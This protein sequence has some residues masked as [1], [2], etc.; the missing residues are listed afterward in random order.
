MPC[1]HCLDCQ[2]P[3]D[4]CQ[5]NVPLVP[6]TW[7]PELPAC[8]DGC[9]QDVW[10]DCVL[11]SEAM[12]LCGDTLPV[13]TQLTDILQQVVAAL[14][15][16]NVPCS[17]VTKTISYTYTGLTKALSYYDTLDPQ[18]FTKSDVI[19]SIGINDNSSVTGDS[20]AYLKYSSLPLLSQHILTSATIGDTFNLPTNTCG[21]HLV[22][23]TNEIWTEMLTTR[24]CFE[25]KVCSLDADRIPWSERWY[26][27]YRANPQ[28]NDMPIIN[29]SGVATNVD[30]GVLYLNDVRPFS[31]I[32]SNGGIVRKVFLNASGTDS[33][34]VRTIAGNITNGSAPVTYNNVWG[35]VV[36][37]DYNSSI[38]IDKR[39]LT[40]GEPALYF[41]TLG[42]VVCR[43]VRERNTECDERANWKNYVIA[44]ANNDPGDI[45][46][47][48]T[49]SRFKKPYGMK[50]WYDINGE[51]S[52]LIVDNGN[53][54]VR[55]MYYID[56]VGGK[57]SSDNWFTVDLAIQCTGIAANINVEDDPTTG[58][59]ANQK[60]I[61]VLDGDRIKIITYTG[62]LTITGTGDLT[63]PTE[64]AGLN[65]RTINTNFAGGQNNAT[66]AGISG[67]G[68]RVY[69]PVT[70]TRVGSAGGPYYYLYTSE[71]A[72]YT[73]PGGAGLVTWSKDLIKIEEDPTLTLGTAGDYTFYKLIDGATTTSTTP[74]EIGL[75]AN[76]NCRSVQ[77][78]FTD[79]QGGVYDVCNGGIRFYD[80]GNAAIDS[81]VSGA[82]AYAQ[83]TIIGVA[84]CPDLAD[85]SSMDTQYELTL[86][87]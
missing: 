85:L 39:E 58:A 28:I 74:S 20:L 21:D 42:G 78:F 52:F 73:C 55:L 15:C 17:E 76:A 7:V 45:Y 54:K 75:F 64:Y 68:A 22:G 31:T 61:W 48:G 18:Y 44:G 62:A 50:K 53:S 24:T 16:T 6:E 46:G 35:D 38:C 1:N 27:C 59:P 43:L 11:T 80:L 57:N 9:L 60:R 12:T 87:C 37:Y 70:I 14:D 84:D 63:D 77:G 5:E 81:I 23:S 34:E 72:A 40:N 71:N 30:R 82:D 66:A 10:T 33:M 65:I 41:C 47:T 25:T 56:G 3:C 13:G 4:Q 69:N 32:A 67:I 51:P 83:T 2:N 86:N 26:Y 36:E 19:T 79:L 29:D 8:T 49:A